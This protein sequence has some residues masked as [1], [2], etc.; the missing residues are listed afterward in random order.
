[1]KLSFLLL[2]LAGLGRAQSFEAAS[3][4]PTQLV[5]Q[6]LQGPV[7]PPVSGYFSYPPEL[8]GVKVTAALGRSQRFI[9][10]G[11]KLQWYLAQALGV[12]WHQVTGNFPQNEG[13]DVSATAGHQV[14]K[15]VAGAMLLNLLVSEFGLQIT[16]SVKGVTACVAEPAPRGL[17][18]TL[19]ANQA[20]AYTLSG[21]KNGGEFSMLIHFRAA[22]TDDILTFIGNSWSCNGV[23]AAQDLH[24]SQTQRFDLDLAYVDTAHAY[25][26]GVEAKEPGPSFVQALEKQAG[27]VLSIKQHPVK[28]WNF[29]WSGKSPKK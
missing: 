2:A 6:Q 16:E 24:L 12:N 19:S 22:T 9:A 1:M 14:T 5:K 10:Q 8:S 11:Y 29:A 23:P 17:K 25:D 21:G 26:T 18:L 7:A 28:V 4:E 15:S 13:W 27:I 3:V 20:D